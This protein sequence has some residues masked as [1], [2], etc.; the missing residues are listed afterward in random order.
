MQNIRD[1]KRDDV[2]IHSLVTEDADWTSVVTLDSFF[3]DVVICSDFDEFESV[4]KSD[5]KLSAIDVAKFFLAVR[6][7][8]HLQLQKL[9]YL[10]YKTYLMNYHRPLFDEKLIAY[11]YGPVVEEVYQKFKKYGS[12]TITVDDRTEYILKDIHLSQALGRMLL[13]KDAEKIVA[14]L[15]S[16]IKKYGDLS[17]G[18]LVELTHSSKGPWDTVFKPHMNCEITDEVILSQASYEKL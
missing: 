2:G 12:E 1:I 15:L 5:S 11:Q 13:I 14:T 3:E 4:L 18:Q 10:A 16:V 9:V 17:A 7:I 8:S 6:P